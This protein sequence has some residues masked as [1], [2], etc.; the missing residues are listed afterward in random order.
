MIYFPQFLSVFFLLVCGAFFAASETAL[1]S[2]SPIQKRRL[3]EKHPKTG[4]IVN[5]LL[6]HPRRTLIAILIGN[7]LAHILAT[8]IVSITTI[9][10]LGE[11]GVGV[12]IALFTTLLIMFGEII[13]KTVAVRNNETVG[14]VT[15]MPL[16][17]FAMA[18]MPVR[19]LVRWI[20]DWTLS[21]I[22]REKLTQSD[23]ISEKELQALIEIGQDEGVLDKR[24]GERLARL[25]ELEERS[26][27]EI[28]TPRT[29]LVA[30]DIQ[31][32]REELTRVLQRY[33]YTYMPVYQDN[34]DNILGVIST[35]E[36]MLNPEKSIRQLLKPPYYIPETK[37]IDELLFE[38][39]K[40]KIYFAL[41]VDE[42]GGTA[43]LVTL[44][45]ILEEVFGEIYDE[46]ARQDNPTAVKVGK[47]EFLLDGKISLKDFSD[48][49][50]VD[51]FS[52]A[53]ETVSGFILEKLGRIPKIKETVKVN[54]LLFEIREVD[55][56]RIAKIHV[57]KLIS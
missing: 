26:V 24:E 45:D 18:I 34:L 16:N 23:K 44:E 11:R 42:Y 53:S 12:A 51:I 54:N 25:F 49:L 6:E 38:M 7:N 40:N 48:L 14:M 37:R 55:R 5:F 28:M 9:H 29:D 8:A 46:Y 39:K 17:Y 13:P 41:C 43:G 4:R 57:R 31:E 56:Q 3:Q 50:G 32:N 1:F 52:E 33:H 2:L 36:L 27:K 35:Q 30:F 20:T 15:A 21:L 10:W 22:I 47:D 19:L